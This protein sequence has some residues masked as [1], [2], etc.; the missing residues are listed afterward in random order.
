[1]VAEVIINVTAK[2][3]NRTFDYIVPKHLEQEIKIGSKVLVPFGNKKVQE[4]FVILFKQQTEYEAKDII[5]VK[6]N[7]LNEENIELAKLMA[8]RYFCTIS[9]CIK[10]MLPPG[11]NSKDI[12]NRIKEKSGNFVYLKKISEEIEQ[13][14]DKRKVK[15]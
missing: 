1:M 7:I 2:G 3:L 8:R 6:E 10:L 12:E 13:D 4:A 15:K 14:I 11:S 5:G 9:D